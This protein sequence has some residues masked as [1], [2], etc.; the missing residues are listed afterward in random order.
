[1]A[2]SVTSPLACV[3]ICCPSFFPPSP[4]RVRKSSGS[5]AS[6]ATQAT[7]ASFPAASAA[8]ATPPCESARTVSVVV[9]GSSFVSALASVTGA[10]YV[11]LRIAPR[12]VARFGSF[13][14]MRSFSASARASTSAGSGGGGVPS[15]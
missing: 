14:T 7:H 8:T 9:R 6:R 10:A 5:P 1:M 4:T 12:A 15:A 11:R 3:I 2:T 13:C